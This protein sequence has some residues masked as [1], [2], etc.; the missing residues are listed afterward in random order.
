MDAA[1]WLNLSALKEESN[2][3]QVILLF[4]LFIFV[5][6][7]QPD[8]SQPCL[9]KDYTQNQVVEQNSYAEIKTEISDLL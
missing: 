2:K 8:V 5:W 4:Y 9:H 7:A 1:F 3:Y 6:K